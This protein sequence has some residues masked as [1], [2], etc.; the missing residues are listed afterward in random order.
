MT[1]EQLKRIFNGERKSIDREIFPEIRT[2]I[3]STNQSIDC[4]R[5][6]MTFDTAHNLLKIKQYK[7][8]CVNGK[9]KK[10]SLISDD[11]M[12]ISGFGPVYIIHPY[13]TFRAPRV[14][15]IVFKVNKSNGITTQLAK[16]V[17]L[18]LDKINLDRPISYNKA[19]ESLCYSSEEFLKEAENDEN[20]YTLFFIY[21][22]MSDNKYDIYL[23]LN[24][25]L[26]IDTVNGEIGLI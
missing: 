3:M 1:I 2:I 16:I 8:K 20:D 25:V 7:Y 21:S 26:G 10:S 13:Y 15:D 22:P 4:R 5:D 23:D 11:G 19:T 14:G 18:D 12:S 6:H 9:I 17:S 24:E